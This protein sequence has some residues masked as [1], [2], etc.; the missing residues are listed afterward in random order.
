MEAVC[1]SPCDGF[2]TTRQYLSDMDVN[3]LRPAG[4]KGKHWFSQ[5]QE[6]ATSYPEIFWDNKG[7]TLRYHPISKNFWNECDECK[8]PIEDDNALNCESC[9]LW[10]A[11]SEK[12]LPINR[13]IVDS[14]LYAYDPAMKVSLN[15]DIVTVL[16]FDHEREVLTT[17]RVKKISE[18]PYDFRDRF[19]NNAQFQLLQSPN[20]KYY[21]P[22]GRTIPDKEVAGL[23]AGYDRVAK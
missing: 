1:M 12:V 20:G 13:I 9:I 3:C 8:I 21:L 15:R 4:H 11:L 17:Q 23:L 5:K 22:F 19:P 2:F 10:I 6:G 18:I 16:W 7:S 14:V